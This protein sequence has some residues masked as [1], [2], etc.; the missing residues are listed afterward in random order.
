MICYVGT[1]V[2]LTVRKWVNLGVLS[3]VTVDTAEAGEGV[4]AINIHGART[5]DTLAAGT[6]EGKRW[7]NLVLNLDESVENL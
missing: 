4:L 3:I 5:A 6:A 1:E 7:I 2:L